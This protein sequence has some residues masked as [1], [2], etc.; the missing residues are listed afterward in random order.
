MKILIVAARDKRNRYEFLSKP[1]DTLGYEVKVVRSVRDVCKSVVIDKY[2]AD[3]IIDVGI[4]LLSAFVRV[5]S[6]IMPG[7]SGFRLLR[8]GGDPISDIS[9]LLSSGV[10]WPHR[11]PIFLKLTLRKREFKFYDGMISVS[12]DLSDRLCEYAPTNCR[13]YIVSQY[14]RLPVCPRK[15]YNVANVL[16]VTNME[17]PEKAAG[18]LKLAEVM[19]VVARTVCAESHVRS[20]NFTVAGGGR[21]LDDLA[22]SLLSFNK[23]KNLNIS[24]L[25]H[26]NDVRDLY[27]DAG[28]F[29]YDSERDAIPN[30]LL[31]AKVMGLPVIAFDNASARDIVRDGVDGFLVNSV[32]AASVRVIELMKDVELLR[33]MG[34]KGQNDVLQRF[35]FEAVTLQVQSMLK[36]LDKTVFDNCQKQPRI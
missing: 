35:S 5:V 25:G 11:I 20:V 17:F 21:Y 28:L 29:I 34:K 8:C 7:N 33:F 24:L 18:V 10:G 1:I 19:R 36:D 6:L 14:V 22:E 13:R 32:Y 12:R 30:V 31:E 27:S 2:K 3:V 26:V 9:V 15:E 16:C 4:G 23:E